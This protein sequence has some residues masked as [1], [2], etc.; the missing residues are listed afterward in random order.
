MVNWNQV[1]LNSLSYK[2]YVYHRQEIC[3]LQSTFIKISPIKINTEYCYLISTKT[4]I[5]LIKDRN[6]I[7]VEYNNNSLFILTKDIFFVFLNIS[8]SKDFKITNFKYL[9][10]GNFILLDSKCFVNIN[11]V[12]SFEFIEKKY[13]ILFDNTLTAIVQKIQ[14][15]NIVS[16][17]KKCIYS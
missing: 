4:I 9:F 2:F 12:L 1:F 3:F 8:K 7:L 17:D 5:H 6:V 16:R 14:I 10:N 11:N 13:R 15:P